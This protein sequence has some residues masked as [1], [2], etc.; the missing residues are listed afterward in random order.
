VNLTIDYADNTTRAVHRLSFVSRG[1]N[2]ENKGCLSSSFVSI[3]T[4]RLVVVRSLVTPLETLTQRLAQV[5]SLATL[6]ASVNV[7]IGGALSNN[8]TGNANVAIGGNAGLNA[9]TGDHNVYI[10]QGMTGVAGESD[11]CYIRSIFGQTSAVGIP[12][13]INSANKLGIAVSSKRFKEDI[14]PMDK[15]SETL[16]A[17]QTGYLPL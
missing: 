2:R 6:P 8:T 13:F 5:C 4:P 11:A 1:D 9:T 14:K 3:R 7:A 17:A 16:L 15:A 12:V 10:G